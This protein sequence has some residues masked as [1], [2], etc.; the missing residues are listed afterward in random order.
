VT[1]STPEGA[2]EWIVGAGMYDDGGGSVAGLLDPVMFGASSYDDSDEPDVIVQPS[3]G[4]VSRETYD[5]MLKRKDGEIE[6]LRAEI[7]V[8]EDHIASLESTVSR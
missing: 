7:R 3:G 5:A 6:M 4:F 1:L 2:H 8:R